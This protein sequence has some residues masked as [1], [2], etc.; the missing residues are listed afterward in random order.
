M[1]LKKLEIQHT[2]Y[3]STNPQGDKYVGKVEFFSAEGNSLTINLR[4]DQL[5]GIVELCTSSIVKAADE[6]AQ[7]IKASLNPLLQITGESHVG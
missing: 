6:A 7:A 1:R 4:E 3:Y 2:H 5:Q